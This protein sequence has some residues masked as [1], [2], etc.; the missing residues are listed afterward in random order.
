[1]TEQHSSATNATNAADSGGDGAARSRPGPTH[2]RDDVAQTLLAAE[3]GAGAEL[4]GHV[5]ADPVGVV[6]ILHGGAE[7]SRMPVAWWRLAVLRM[8]PFASTISRRSGDDLVVLRLKYRVRGWNGTRQDPVQ[9]ARWALD[10]IRHTLPGV[11]VVAVGHSMGGRVALHLS[12]EP[13]VVGVAALAPWVESDVRQPP[14]GV[15]VLLMHGSSD[16]VTDPRRTDVIAR[17]YAQAG[18][19]LRYVRVEGGTHTMLKD[20]ALWHDT[21]ADFVTDVLLGPARTS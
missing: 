2:R 14:P 10:R 20:A 18:V 21:V 16:H 11:P 4:R 15:A 7:A 13:D 9:D 17:R 6:L 1:M 19:D 5:P 12:A 3:G 8:V